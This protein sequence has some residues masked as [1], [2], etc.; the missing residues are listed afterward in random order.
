MKKTC[1]YCQQEF[2]PAATR[3]HGIDGAPTC[4]PCMKAVPEREALAEQMMDAA[5]KNPGVYVITKNGMEVLPLSA[6]VEDILALEPL[7]VSIKN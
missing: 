5:T 1:C 2:T 6:G 3:P 4:F 7:S